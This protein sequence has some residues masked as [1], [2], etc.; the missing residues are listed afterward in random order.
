MYGKS[1]ESK[2]EGSMVGAGLNVFAVWDY[3]IAKCKT[4]V[5]EINPKLLA[6][7]LGGTE[8]QIQDALD[9]LCAPDPKSRSKAED[10][11]R[12]IKEGEYQYRMVNWAHYQG[13]K[14]AEALK[15][16]N[17]EQQR[18]HRLRETIKKLKKKKTILPGE[19]AYLKALEEGADEETLSKLAEPK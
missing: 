6:F 15:E 4:G 12:L 5:I 10:G 2:Y 11:R 17:R 13:I 9:K 16:Y 8:D 14:N 18:A 3:A 1:Y 7:I 19:L